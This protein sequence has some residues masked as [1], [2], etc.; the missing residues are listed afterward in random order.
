MTKLNE[1]LWAVAK[2]YARLFGN[3]IDSRVEY[4]V[5][6][7]PELCCFCDCY[8][9]TLDEMRVVVDKIDDYSR[10]YGSRE[11]V[12]HEVMAWA[13]WVMD[14]ALDTL[15]EYATK[16]VTHQL[17]PNIN[18]ESWLNGCPREGRKPF[19]GPDALLFQLRND[20]ETLERLIS[21]YRDN[22]TLANVLANLQAKLDIEEKNKAERDF[23]E[24][25]FIGRRQEE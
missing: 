12:G 16:R 5:G 4:W 22:R 21:E 19:D 11:A 10:K 1:H 9:F 6:D 24:W 7:E 2:E 20:V 18:L 15:M 25:E 8:F 17:R 3:I 14:G 13:D 23:K